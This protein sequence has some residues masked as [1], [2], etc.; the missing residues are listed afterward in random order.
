MGKRYK[1]DSRGRKR[2]I[3]YISGED[4]T[5]ANNDFGGGFVRNYLVC[6]VSAV[7]IVASAFVIMNHWLSSLHERA[8]GD[9]TAGAP[10]GMWSNG[11]GSPPTY[12]QPDA[13][14]QSGH[15]QCLPPAPVTNSHPEPPPHPN[16]NHLPHPFIQPCINSPLHLPSVGRSVLLLVKRQG[17]LIG[18]SEGDSSLAS[19]CVCVCV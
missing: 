17:R 5:S 13:G 19:V 3:S 12:I 2:D 16:S 1:P 15:H 8:R 4:E 11:P 10:S 7:L 18:Q 9:V 6:V 14:K